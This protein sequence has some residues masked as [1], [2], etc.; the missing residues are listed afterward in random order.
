MR[1]RVRWERAGRADPAGSA[2]AFAEPAK[3]RPGVEPQS[4]EAAL[5]D[6]ARRYPDRPATVAPDGHRSY[7]EI[8]AGALSVAR[9]LAAD[10]GVGSG[11]RVGLVLDTTPAYAAAFHGVLLS[12]GVAVPISPALGARRI[13][14]LV[15]WTGCR[16][17]LEDATGDRSSA[18]MLDL[19][20]RLPDGSAAAPRTDPRELAA[21][22][23]T[24]G[25][26]GPPKAVMLSR[27]NLV[28][29]AAA[30]GRSVLGLRASDRALVTLP[31]HHAFGNSVL[32][33]H[34]LAGS[35]LVFD[36]AARFSPLDAV[37][38]HG[39]TALYEVPDRCVLLERALRESPVPASLRYLAVAG[40]R[41][42]PALAIALRGALSP[43]ELVV[44]YGQSEATARLT[45]LD[46]AWLAR[47]PES[48]GRPIPGVE[49][50]VVDDAGRALEAGTVGAIRARGRGICLGYWRD[51]AA[52]AEILR[53][54]WLWTMDRGSL[55]AFGLLHHA[56]RVDDVVKIG[57][58]RVD[59][60]R[61]CRDVE[62]ATGAHRAAA[63]PF[64]TAEGATRIALFAIGRPA[65]RE[66]ILAWCRSSL[67]RDERPAL[68]EPVESL[69]TLAS[70]KPDT[71]ALAARARL[72]WSGPAR[73]GRTTATG[74]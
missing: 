3:D 21:I 6:T 16:V 56:G 40:G 31:F 9:F 14:E 29:N 49:I 66:A 73:A 39:V 19:E 65:L 2:A 62:A 37:S 24:S 61:L 51:P 70:G 13:A 25:T 72:L 74:R 22:L 46:P 64:Q 41:L 8:A 60:G 54:G 15:A 52:T 44:M 63:V 68:I 23:L 11:D 53:D 27:D 26:S 12:G 34:L 47:A 35:C 58:R 33:S 17:V 43:A 71:T 57:G 4:L 36:P 5:L 32:Q 67:S 50:E 42:S 7:A 48:V 55:D 30:I 28:S 20:T 10:A 45:C 59:L 1:A 69:P 38:R 18:P